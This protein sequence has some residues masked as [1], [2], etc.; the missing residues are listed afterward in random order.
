MADAIL[1]TMTADRKSLA[2]KAEAWYA[3][4]PRE[5]ICFVLALLFSVSVAGV[6]WHLSHLSLTLAESA[7]RRTASHYIEMLEAFRALYTSEVVERVTAHGIEATQD[8]LMRE[9]TIPLPA[10]L[11]MALGKRLSETA[12]G[13]QVRL[14]SAYPFPWRADGGPRDDFEREALRRLEAQPAQPF[15][16]LEEFQGRQSLRYAIAD[17]LQ[18]SCVSCHNHHPDSPKTDWQEGDVRGVLE[19]I[20]PL[21]QAHAQT[22]TDLRETF[23]FFALLAMV[24][25]FGLGLVIHFIVGQK[26]LEAEQAHLL[27]QAEAAET[28]FRELLESAPEAIVLVNLNGI[29]VLVNHQTEK[30]FGC[31]REEL[32]GKA[33]E[34]LMPESLRQAH[35]RHRASY[36]S[37]P[38]MRP[39]GSF[40]EVSAQ[41]ADGSEF[42]AE[43]SLS[44]IESNGERL[45]MSVIRDIT[46]RKR[47]ADA[48][49]ESQER[50]RTIAEMTP[51]PLVISRVSD[52]LILYA[53]ERLGPLLGLPVTELI[54]N[55]SPDF[56]YDPADRQ[57]VFT[58]LSER[59]TLHDY[60]LR[61]KKP[62]GASFWGSLS[63]RKITFNGEPALASAIYDLTD[64]KQIEQ[65]LRQAK[66]EAEAANRLK[67]EFLATMSHEIRTPM[68]GVMGMT[69][70]LLDTD[71]TPEQRDY[72]E[73]VKHSADTL[74]T[75]I[76]DILDFS[77]VEA[78][79]LALEIID[80]D[81]RVAIEE[82][83]DLLA[84]QAHEKG[85]EL[86]CL[87]HADVPVALRGDPGRLRQILLNLLNN[88]IKFTQQGEVVV[89]VKKA[90]S[91]KRKAVSDEQATGN[92]LLPPAYCLLEFTVRDTGIGIPADRRD[93]LFRAFSQV[94]SSTTRKYGG[95]GLGLSIGKRL[96][97]LMG[98]EIGVESEPGKG[99]TF[100]FTVHLERQAGDTQ[101][102]PLPHANLRGLRVLVVDDN[103]ASRTALS[104]FCTSREMECDGVAD[105]TQGLER[106]RGAAAQG[107]PYHVALLDSRLPDMDGLA[108]T[109]AIKAD[110]ALATLKLVLLPTIGLRGEA[111]QAQ[112]TGV[113][114][115][116][117]KPV[118]QSQLFACLTTVMGSALVQ[119]PPSFAPLVTR[120][121][122]A[123]IKSRT[124]PLILVVEDNAVNQKLAVRLLD[125]LGYRTDVAANGR[126]ALDALAR[127]PYAAVLMDCQMP[128]MDGYEATKAIRVREATSYPPSRG[129]KHQTLNSQTPDAR[130]IPI[131]AMTANAMQG[132][133]ERCLAAGMDDYISKPVNAAALKAVLERWLAKPEPADSPDS[134]L[135][136]DGGA[137]AHGQI[138][139]QI[140][141]TDRRG[142]NGFLEEAFLESIP[143][144]SRTRSYTHEDTTC[145]G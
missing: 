117:P 50:F 66:E 27:R 60:E 118:H 63:I 65:N 99:S 101:S 80:F 111:Q 16:R 48:L 141:T 103:T 122:L 104:L 35:I 132:D 102:A 84:P 52:G 69:G 77:K 78:G 76:N 120:H 9:K 34:R 57:A 119:E 140:K 106:L 72:A 127:L 40:R 108:L 68:N 22:S 4:L 94:N 82:T 86:T 51:I 24:G 18:S 116:L 109:R 143:T 5:R 53:N 25:L 91:S 135:A 136:Y 126:E 41:R 100:W 30:L 45:I 142:K 92:C 90:E 114:A 113:D 21:D 28:K 2:V 79:K 85:L 97:E 20:F 110:P 49:K 43:I 138:N 107:Q 7:T 38:Q 115:Y 125:K 124:R 121:T 133:K 70:L 56:Y 17:R 42:P 54:G 31:R 67:S 128:E 131:I 10:T 59:E 11:T 144:E 81:L 137:N 74:L 58:L 83:L 46:E 29:I 134:F 93:R 55:K 95:T 15:T 12:S 75:I 64:R 61:L 26:R 47:T 37:N 98:G 129:A 13:M 14:Y 112:K 73:T 8:Y 88:A 87:V 3:S 130:R 62:D 19:V 23:L 123:E 145:R 139:T 32:L 6:V 36:L 1:E 89:S 96:V 105:S 44:P 39:M 33:I 71:L